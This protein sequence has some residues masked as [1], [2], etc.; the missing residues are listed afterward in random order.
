MY[1]IYYVEII[2][3]RL[4]N[5]EYMLTQKS[6]RRLLICLNTFLNLNK[7]KDNQL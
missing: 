3:L 1:I 2:E 7:H 4:R 5:I 6:L